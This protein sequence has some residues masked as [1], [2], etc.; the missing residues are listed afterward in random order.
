MHDTLCYKYFQYASKAGK[1]ILQFNEYDDL[2]SLVYRDGM[3]VVKAKY[4]VDKKE[5]KQYVFYIETM[6]MIFGKAFD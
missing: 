1:P 5:L 4:F 2:Q 3:T 6:N